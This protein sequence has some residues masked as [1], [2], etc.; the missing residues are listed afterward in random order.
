MSDALEAP[1]FLRLSNVSLS[2]FDAYLSA[3]VRH[4]R[5]VQPPKGGG[6]VEKNRHVRYVEHLRALVELGASIADSVARE[7]VL[8]IS[9]DL[10]L[11]KVCEADAERQR[12]LWIVELLVAH[13][14]TG[15]EVDAGLQQVVVALDVVVVDVYQRELNTSTLLGPQG[16]KE[17]VLLSTRNMEHCS[18]CI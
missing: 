16:M 10:R 8:G 5:Y 17:D 1:S 11:A 9:D 2:F 18:T 14:T 7:L 3:T 4:P 15:E 6:R 12:A 13:R